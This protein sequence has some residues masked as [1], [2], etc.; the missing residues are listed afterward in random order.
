MDIVDPELVFKKYEYLTSASQPMCDHFIKMGNDLVDQFDIKQEDLVVE[1]GGNDGVL[2]NAI[3]DKCRVLNVD[4]AVDAAKMSKEKGIATLN[5][6]FTCDT[7]A[8]IG[9]AKLVIANNV[10]AHIEDIVGTFLGVGQLIQDGGVFVLEVHWLGNLIGSG[11][12]DQIYHEH[13]YYHS[14]TA[15]NHLVEATG[16]VIFDV[17]MEPIHGQSMRV[18]VGDRKPTQAVDDLLKQEQILGLDKEET[19]TAFADKIE[20]NRINLVT[21]CKLLRLKGKSIVGY[22]APAKGNTLLNYFNIK[23]DYVIDTT[24]LKQGLYT[25]GMHMRVRK[26][27]RVLTEPPDYFLLLA[28]NYAD[29]ILEK[30]KTLRD[31]GTKF[32]IPVPETRVV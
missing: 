11:G 30:E 28:W 23:L 5:E 3:K 2:L 24:P 16:M 12:F 6:F 17:Q 19:F 25:P 9:R 8:K 29:T 21:L 7:V 27:E 15:L 1:I 20:N 13:I 4:P 26:P 22:G 32:I 14:L 31:A 10:M 18:F